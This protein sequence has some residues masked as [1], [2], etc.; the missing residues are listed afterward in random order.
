MSSTWILH[1]F[2]CMGFGLLQRS[3]FWQR[4]AYILLFAYAH[5]SRR[6]YIDGDYFLRDVSSMIELFGS[7]T[8]TIRNVSGSYDYHM[9]VNAP[10]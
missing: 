10:T 6:L 3:S 8:P 9:S 7:P 2:Q 4:P 1:G 5:S